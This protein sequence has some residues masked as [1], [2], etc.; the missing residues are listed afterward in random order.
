MLYSITLK[1]DSTVVK[2]HIKNIPMGNEMRYRVL[3]YGFPQYCIYSRG[4]VRRDDEHRVGSVSVDS[5][6]HIAINVGRN[7]VSIAQ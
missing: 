3:N 5:P 6:W 2:K 7:T 4:I 1:L